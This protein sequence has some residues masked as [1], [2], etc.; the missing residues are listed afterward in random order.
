MAVT[1][2]VNV[3][4]ATPNYS[5]NK[6]SGFINLWLPNKSGGRRKLGAI[7]LH[8]NK[9]AEAS[10]LDY[11]NEDPS[12]IGNLLSKLQADYQPVS[13]DTAAH[14]DLDDTP[15]IAVNGSVDPQADT[16]VS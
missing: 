3:F 14:F 15:A 12:R 7:P 5:N 4:S 6:A 8:A 16:K 1:K 9:A 13:N 11:L 2:S 10:L